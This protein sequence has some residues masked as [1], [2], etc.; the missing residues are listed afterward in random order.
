VIGLSTMLVKE[1]C[2]QW[3]TRRLLV[4][5]VVF[6][7][8]GIASPLLARYTPELVSMLAAD[9][10][11]V[12]EVPPPTTADAIAQ[13]VRNIGQTGVLAAILLAMGS[14]ATEKERGTAALW[15]TKPLTRGA[16]LLAKAIGISGVL[17]AGM[18]VAGIAGYGYTAY[19]F[20]APSGAGWLAMC[21]LLLLQMSAYA[22]LTFLG[23]TLTRSPLAAAGIGIGALTVMAIVGALPVIGV[24]TPSGLAELAMALAAG[25]PPD[26]PVEPILATMAVIAVALVAAWLSFRRQEL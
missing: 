13:F 14:V 19:L 2:E 10:G 23:S 15:L 24:W 9:E 3:R 22:A 1:L 17:M 6:L 21:A 16:F 18:A 20:D 8:F 4:V 7:A 26:K 5:A 25:T 12:I 11:L